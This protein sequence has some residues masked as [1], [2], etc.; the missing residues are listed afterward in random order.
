M[1]QN[2]RF[3]ICNKFIAGMSDLAWNQ[4]PILIG[5]HQKSGALL[6]KP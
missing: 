6:D 3:M 1:Y 2:D 4:C 5:G